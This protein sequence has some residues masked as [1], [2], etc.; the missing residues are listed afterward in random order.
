MS[1]SKRVR[2]FCHDPLVVDPEALVYWSDV[3]VKFKGKPGRKLYEYGPTLISGADMENTLESN[4][5]F[6]AKH[7]EDHDL[8]P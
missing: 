4:R 6:L 1:R 5:E 8:T 7:P 2:L 3:W